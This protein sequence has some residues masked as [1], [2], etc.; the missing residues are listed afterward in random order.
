MSIL[1]RLRC[2]RYAV[3][4][5]AIHASYYGGVNCVVS[6]IKSIFILAIGYQFIQPPL[7]SEHPSQSPRRHPDFVRGADM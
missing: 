4:K 5:R 3:Y 1:R 7:R 2:T 6:L